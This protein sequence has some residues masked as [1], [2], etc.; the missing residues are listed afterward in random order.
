MLYRETIA[1]CFG[2]RRKH[3]NTLCMPSVE[4]LNVEFCGTCSNYAALEA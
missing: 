3:V 4:F 2:I 1:I